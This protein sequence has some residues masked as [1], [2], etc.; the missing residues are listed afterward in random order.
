[1]RALVSRVLPLLAV[2]LLIVN[3][4]VLKHQ[5]PGFVTGKLSD[6]AGLFFFPLLL[7]DALGRLHG[8][9][10]LN[11]LVGACIATAVVFAAVKTWGPA[12]EMYCVGLGALQWPFRALVASLVSAPLPALAR[13]RLTMDVT[14]LVGLVSVAA[15]F[16]YALRY[17]G[18]PRRPR[19]GD[20]TTAGSY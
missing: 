12:H 15:A 2:A 4:H 8:R 1:M 11:M 13:V 6:F 20:F 3:D 19:S 16:R 17:G 14:D 9:R 7:V 18:V 10:S 5:F